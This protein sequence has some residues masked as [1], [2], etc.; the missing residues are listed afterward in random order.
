MSTIHVRVD[1]ETK[2]QAGEVF[3]DLGIDVSTGVKLFLRQVITEKGI[4]FTPS[5]SPA[6]VKAKWD[7]EVADALEKK[8][9]Y[10][11]GKKLLNALKET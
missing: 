9:G 8:Q 6:I 7:A 3:A 11:S 5:T 10:T 1:E 2:K 4:P